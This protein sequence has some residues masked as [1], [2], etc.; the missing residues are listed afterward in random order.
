[1][2]PPYGY[3][4][5]LSGGRRARPTLLAVSERRVTRLP[6][7][8]LFHSAA[9]IAAPYSCARQGPRSAMLARS[10]SD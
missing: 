3:L 9:R 10:A 5:Y 6:Y 2:R 8:F 7:G 1:M 4:L